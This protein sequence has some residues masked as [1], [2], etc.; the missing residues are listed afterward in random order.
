MRVRRVQRPIVVLVALFLGLGGLGTA[1]GAALG[2][3]GGHAAAAPFDG[4]HHHGPAGPRPG[5]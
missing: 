4:H 1:A 3:V 5:G 2:A